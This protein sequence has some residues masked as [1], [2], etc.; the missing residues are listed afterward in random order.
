M[1]T[2]ASTAR[3]GNERVPGA[4]PVPCFQRAADGEQQSDVLVGSEPR[5]QVRGN[6]R[7]QAVADDDELSWPHLVEHQIADPLAAHAVP[8][9]ILQPFP[10]H[11]G[12][13]P[14]QRARQPGVGR[15]LPPLF[16]EQPAQL[17]L[18][19]WYAFLA[20][21]VES[22]RPNRSDFSFFRLRSVLR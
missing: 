20:P 21:A 10:G 17:P 9:G 5:Q 11:P 19:G 18:V 12:R 1:L 16:G 22:E 14:S 13:V 6:D 15:L 7:S 3:N 4:A 8:L 2:H